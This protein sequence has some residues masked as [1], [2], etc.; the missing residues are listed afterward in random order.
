MKRMGRGTRKH[1]NNTQLLA[2][3]GEGHGVEKTEMYKEKVG[4][5]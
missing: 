5:W 1:T 4:K 3:L 2:V